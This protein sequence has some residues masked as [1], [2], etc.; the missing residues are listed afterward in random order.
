MSLSEGAFARKYSMKAC[1]AVAVLELPPSVSWLMN[2]PS[3]PKY[4]AIWI[5]LSATGNVLPDFCSKA[6][7]LAKLPP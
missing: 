7:T 4:C 3:N 2:Q 5:N 6:V 1:M